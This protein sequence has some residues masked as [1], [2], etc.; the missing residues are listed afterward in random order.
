[1]GG[2]ISTDSR[3]G[4]GS[5]FTVILEFRI[6]HSREEKSEKSKDSSG[7]NFGGKRYLL[8]EDNDINAEIMM[9]LLK[10]RGAEAVRVNNGQKAVELFAAHREGYFDA[11]FM[12]VMMPVMN[13]YEATK[14]LRALERADAK[15][16]IIVAMTANAFAEDIKAALDSGMDDHSAKPI[17]IERL[18]D[19]LEQSETDKGNEK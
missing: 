13:G 11:V 16:V 10:M 8:A 7:Y 19:I 4:E 17:S 1:M 12:D 5:T 2:T 3:Q 18:A 14:A 15:A 6:D 9:E